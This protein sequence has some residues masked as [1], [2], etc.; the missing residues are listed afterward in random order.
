MWTETKGLTFL[1]L[2]VVMAIIAITVIFMTPAIG[3]WVEKYRVNQ[4][5]R[6]MV[7]D[8]QFAKIKAITMGR[9]Y[10]T[11]TF[12]ITIDNVHFDYIIY[13]DCDRDLE[14][15]L[16]NICDMDGDGTNES[17]EKDNIFKGIQ[18]IHDNYRHV[19][20]DISQ[21]DGDGIT[22]TDNDD[23]QPS[24][25]FDAQGFPR[26]NS[27]GFGAGSVYLKNTKNNMGR[28]IIVSSTG[29]IRIAKY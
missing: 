5:A 14:L 29:R 21:G 16:A 2:A 15:D 22:F 26:N 17:S 23:G 12:N 20:F 28:Q 3:E 19:T 7:S 8:L 11:V 27:G 10:C 4:A 9:Y 6:E 25:A 13:P 24:I 18:R 1:E